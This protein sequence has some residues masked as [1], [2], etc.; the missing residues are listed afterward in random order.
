MV[1]KSSKGSHYSWP[2]RPATFYLHCRRLGR[3]QGYLPVK[4]GQI[5]GWPSGSSVSDV[6]GHACMQVHAHKNNNEKA[7][8]ANQ[9]SRGRCILANY[10]AHIQMYICPIRQQTGVWRYLLMTH[11]HKHTK[12][13]NCDRGLYL[14][15]YFSGAWW[16]EQLVCTYVTFVTHLNTWLVR[17]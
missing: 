16:F 8:T 1:V 2:P 9:T 7:N 15:V 13:R 6:T 11:S 14:M 5:T 12:K 10:T 3:C 4:I 17:R